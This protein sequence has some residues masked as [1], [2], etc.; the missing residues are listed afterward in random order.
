[1][2]NI[3]QLVTKLNDKYQLERN[4]FKK[5]RNHVFYDL[6]VFRDNSIINKK[7]EK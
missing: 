5:I 3:C 4:D 1:M 7:M 6:V 2:K